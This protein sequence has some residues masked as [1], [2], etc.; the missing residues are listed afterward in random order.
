MGIDLWKYKRKPAKRKE[1]ISKNVYLSLVCEIYKTLS[2]KT[3]SKF[4]TTVY[5]YLCFTKLN[6]A[7]VS[8]RRLQDSYDTLEDTARKEG[9][10]VEEILVVAGPVV[11]D[12]RLVNIR[13]MRVVALRF[14]KTA[15]AKLAKAGGEC[16][17]FD[18]LALLRP[19]GEKCILFRG[20]I[21]DR[22]AAKCFGVPGRRDGARPKC[23]AKSFKKTEKKSKKTKNKKVSFKGAE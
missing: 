10:K 4:N 20:N 1:P 19:T 11:D 13:P 15:R 3:Q 17:T 5:K 21:L 23:A 8:L 6:K 12:E 16:L 22:K 7:C 18:Q 14:S 9:T 2:Q